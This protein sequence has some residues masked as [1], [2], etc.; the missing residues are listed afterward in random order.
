MAQHG[1]RRTRRL[2]LT[3]LEARRML[4]AQ[5]RWRWSPPIPAAFATAN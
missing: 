4:G 1:A 2:R 5:S 3:E